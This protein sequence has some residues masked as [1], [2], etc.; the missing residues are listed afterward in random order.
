MTPLSRLTV[1]AA[2]SYRTVSSSSWQSATLGE[3]GHH[4]LQP[5]H[6]GSE[7]KKSFIYNKFK[8]GAEPNEPK[9]PK[10]P[11]QVTHTPSI[12][13]EPSK[14]L[15]T[16]ESTGFVPSFPNPDRRALPH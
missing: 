1:A 2:N 14:S 11:N 6:L 13:N 15:K 10:E 7:P 4:S 3:K 12:P 16:Q 9:E 5:A 8:L